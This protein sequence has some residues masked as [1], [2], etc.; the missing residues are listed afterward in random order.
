MAIEVRGDGNQRRGPG[1]DSGSG[2]TCRKLET[3]A[4]LKRDLR[5]APAAMWECDLGVARASDVFI[6]SCLIW[7]CTANSLTS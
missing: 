1:W 2:G 7:V 3:G 6:L 4:R 5:W